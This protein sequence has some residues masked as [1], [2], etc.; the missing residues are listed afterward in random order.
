MN[1]KFFSGL[2]PHK[3]RELA[4]GW[5]TPLLIVHPR[6]IR[7]NVSRIRGALDPTMEVRYAVKAGASPAI[8]ETLEPLGV[9]LDVASRTEA[10]IALALGYVSSRLNYYAPGLTKENFEFLNSQRISL[11][12]DSTHQADLVANRRPMSTR[13]SLRISPSLRLREGDAAVIAT[14]SN[15]LG[16]SAEEAIAT[17][18][19]LRKLGIPVTGLHAHIGSQV[20]V[21]EPYICLAEELATLAATIG[22]IEVINLG[23]GMAVDYG[24]EGA[25]FPFDILGKVLRAKVKAFD[26]FHWVIEP[27]RAIAAGG[28]VMVTR[29]LDTK[30]AGGKRFII[31]DARL[32]SLEIELPVINCSQPTVKNINDTVLCGTACSHH[33][34]IRQGDLPDCKVGDIFALGMVGAYVIQLEGYLHLRPKALELVLSDEGE[35]VIYRT[36]PSSDHFLK[37]SL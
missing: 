33:D 17:A 15:K 31:L 26:Y 35:I 3:I 19:R 10:E 12:L 32:N 30:S 27:G 1:E 23:G 28:A 5:G 4:E 7:E 24:A 20:E 25:N 29:V 9:S 13:I 22:G 36:P 6:R 16:M 21:V 18:G 2:G 14:G 11:S 34:I 8:L 37:L